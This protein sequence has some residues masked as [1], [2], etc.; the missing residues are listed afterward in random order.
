M[1]AQEAVLDYVEVSKIKPDPGNP[2]KTFG[3][4]EQAAL[5]ASVKQHGVQTPLRLRGNGNGG[6][7]IVAG[8]R[9]WRAAK[10]AKL[11]TVPAIVI[12][13]TES[14]VESLVENLVREDLNPIEEGDAYVALSA[15]GQSIPEIATAVSRPTQRVEDRIL[16]AGLPAVARDAVISGKVPLSKVRPLAVI[17]KDQPGMAEAFAW[18]LNAQGDDWRQADNLGWLYFQ[19]DRVDP[20]RTEEECSVCEG[21]G[22]ATTDDE[23]DFGPCKECNG[24]GMIVGRDESAPGVPKFFA[25][26]VGRFNAIPLVE[27]MLGQLTD[28]AKSRLVVSLKK[29]TDHAEE[30]RK[31]RGYADSAPAP[32]L[33][34]DLVDVANAAGVLFKIDGNR[35]VVTD[36]EWVSEFL[37]DDYERVVAAFVAGEKKP[38][39]SRAAGSGS[40]M[41]DEEREKRAGER[42]EAKKARAKGRSFNA[43]LGIAIQQ[44]IGEVPVTTEA[45]KLLVGT[46]IDESEHRDYQG[47]QGRGHALF[48]RLTDTTW[49]TTKQGDFVIP[50]S[51]VDRREYVE[52]VYKRTRKELAAA[53]SPEQALA[54]LVRFFAPGLADCAGL[55]EGDLN[56]MLPY[57]TGRWRKFVA[58]RLPTGLKRRVPKENGI[59]GRSYAWSD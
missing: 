32:T 38:S 35:E 11:K 45:M 17:A 9:R 52:A 29:A 37:P 49:K 46:I 14:S 55:G 19:L 7:I 4:E 54:V 43:D 6:F 16:L 23:N 39:A 12:D 58:D 24:N 51:A 22:D 50:R 1:S 31:A 21:T 18:A 36:P 30:K 47:T 33:S 26:P 41:T 44:S 28:D 34:D 13:A 8:E 42:E 59:K 48:H 27:M 10:E 56:E 5:V 57:R 25:W 53:K 15:A 3:V 40:T 2:R 20:T